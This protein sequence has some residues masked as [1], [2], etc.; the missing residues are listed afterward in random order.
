[1][2]LMTM[3]PNRQTEP[4]DDAQTVIRPMLCIKCGCDLRGC[5]LE[6]NCPTCRHPVYDSVYG[7]YLIDASPRE[8]RRLLEM[9]NIVLYPALFLGVLTAII[10]L[11]A[12]VRWRSFPDTVSNVFDDAFF[13]AMLSPLVALVGSVVFTGRRSADYYVAKY[14]N[15]RTVITATGILLVSVTFVGF[16]LWYF[17][18]WAGA[19]FRVLFAT[20]PAATF[21][22]RFAGLMRRIPNKKLAVRAGFAHF[23]AWALGTAALLILLLRPFTIGNQ[24]LEGFVTALTLI[25]TCGGLGLGIAVIRLL[26]LARRTL[27]AIN[28]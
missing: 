4:V 16:A 27:R 3:K 26:V 18:Y 15:P 17:D 28:L 8:P 9:S 12:L 19:V 23:C 20:I 21:L 10:V 7:G 25:T 14:G 1:M 6:A 22:S 13:C 2:G 5:S 11:A 24:D